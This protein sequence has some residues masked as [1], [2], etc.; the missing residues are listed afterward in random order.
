MT[1]SEARKRGAFSLC[2]ASGAKS[3]D[4]YQTWRDGREKEGQMKGAAKV[5]TMWTRHSSLSSHCQICLQLGDP[6]DVGL[7]SLP[8][9]DG[10]AD[11]EASGGMASVSV[12]E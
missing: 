2:R 7:V 6:S 4:S 9:Q 10:C 5:K 8:G 1:Y 12:V 3:G 11:G